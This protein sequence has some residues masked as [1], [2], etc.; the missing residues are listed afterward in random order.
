MFFIFQGGNELVKL[1]IDREDKRVWIASS[2]TNYKNIET[3]WRQLFDKGKEEEQEKITDKLN[4]EE[5][6]QLIILQMAKF[7]YTLKKSE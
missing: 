4:D 6:K 2:N 5:F 1:N 3:S 7:G